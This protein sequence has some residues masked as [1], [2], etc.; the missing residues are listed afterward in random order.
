MLKNANRL[1]PRKAVLTDFSGQLRQEIASLKAARADVDQVSQEN[2]I[3]MARIEIARLEAQKQEIIAQA[4]AQRANL[5]KVGKESITYCFFCHP[6]TITHRKQARSGVN[7][8]G[9]AV[10]RTVRCQKPTTFL[11]GRW[12]KSQEKTISTK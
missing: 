8:T 4:N 12:C 9:L 3:K 7:L 6:L 10:R 5:A 1:K 11:V 2:Q